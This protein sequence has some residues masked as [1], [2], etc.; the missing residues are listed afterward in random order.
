MRANYRRSWA[1]LTYRA[2]DHQRGHKAY[3]SRHWL[4]AVITRPSD[5]K[6][7]RKRKNDD[8]WLVMSQPQRWTWFNRT[9]IQ[10]SQRVLYASRTFVLF[11]K[12]LCVVGPRCET[13]IGPAKSCS[14]CSDHGGRFNSKFLKYPIV[15]PHPSEQTMRR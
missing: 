13:R 14:S 12:E 5:K 11:S 9:V 1:I 7:W 8:Y 6:Y 3:G 4:Q 10:Q 15:A 2:S